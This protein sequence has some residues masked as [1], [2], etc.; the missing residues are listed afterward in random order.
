[1]LSRQCKRL[2]NRN[3]RRN[4]HCYKEKL[5]LQIIYIHTPKMTFT[6]TSS[7]FLLKD[8]IDHEF[9]WFARP[10]YSYMKPTRIHMLRRLLTN[11]QGGFILK[12]LRKLQCH[13]GKVALSLLLG[14]YYR[15]VV[16]YKRL[17]LR[18]SRPKKVKE[19]GEEEHKPDCTTIVKELLGQFMVS[20]LF[21]HNNNLFIV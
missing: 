14:L 9:T 17:R 6:H 19:K 13:L 3:T 15:I 10:H 1:M 18:L 11:I 5:F 4:L 7:A 12:P 8:H 21:S 16:S 2:I 20:T